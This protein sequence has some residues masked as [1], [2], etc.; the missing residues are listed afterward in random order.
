M[1]T[2]KEIMRLTRVTIRNVDQEVIDRVRLHIRRYGISLGGIVTAA[3]ADHLDRVEDIT[4]RHPG[5]AG[6]D[7]EPPAL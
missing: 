5:E 7:L 2:E 4:G 3:L 1:E 6:Y